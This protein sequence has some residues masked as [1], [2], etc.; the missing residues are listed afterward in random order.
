MYLATLAALRHCSM[1]LSSLGSGLAK[2]SFDFLRGCLNVGFRSFIYRE[3][4]RIQQL[5][6]P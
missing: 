1:N 6:V 2:T 3:R 5:T 4:L